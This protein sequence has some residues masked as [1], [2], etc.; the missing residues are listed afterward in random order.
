MRLTAF[1]TIASYVARKYASLVPNSSWNARLE[2]PASATSLARVA[3][4]Y[5]CSATSSII[6]PIKR[7]R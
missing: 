7:L 1:A 5:P 3:A 4:G 6:A 2:T